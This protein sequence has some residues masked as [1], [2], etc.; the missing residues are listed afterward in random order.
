MRCTVEPGAA[1]VVVPDSSPVDVL[2]R[3]RKTVN[4]P[5]TS[6]AVARRSCPSAGNGDAAADRRLFGLISSQATA[7]T[8]PN[9]APQASGRNTDGAHTAA[10]AADAIMSGSQTVR[11]RLTAAP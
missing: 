8:E 1:S 3:A 5:L 9:I 6:D 7:A 11:Q 4:A 2:T 10:K